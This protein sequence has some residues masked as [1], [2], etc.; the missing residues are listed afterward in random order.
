MDKDIIKSNDTKSAITKQKTEINKLQLEESQKKNVEE[1]SAVKK[2]IKHTDDAENHISFRDY[3]G[4][5]KYDNLTSSNLKINK[6]ETHKTEEPK[7]D[8]NIKTESDKQ[9]VIK[10]KETENAVKT[11]D[12]N[13]NGVVKSADSKS[14]FHQNT[15]DVSES[16][17]GN[18]AYSS[19]AFHYSEQASGQGIVKLNNS[20][21]I[22]TNNST[23]VIKSDNNVGIVKAT[24]FKDTFKKAVKRKIH[25]K[26]KEKYSKQ[27]TGK[28]GYAR[29]DYNKQE[30]IVKNTVNVINKS[31]NYKSNVN[32]KDTAFTYKDSILNGADNSNIAVSSAQNR[33]QKAVKTNIQKKQ[34]DTVKAK[35]DKKSDINAVKVVDNS[36]INTAPSVVRSMI[37][38]QTSVVK[39]S[40][41]AYRYTD[42]N[43]YAQSTFKPEPKINYN[44][45]PKNYN[46]KS[47]K[48]VVKPKNDYGIVKSSEYI[49]ADTV[50]NQ[51]ENSETQ[52]DKATLKGARAVATAAYIIKPENVVKA[53]TT[54]SS[55]KQKINKKRI[56]D[57]KKNLNIK[58]EA[59]N[60]LKKAILQNNMRAKKAVNVGK[61]AIVKGIKDGIE[62]AGNNDMPVKAIDDVIKTAD[63]VVGVKNGIKATVNTTKSAAKT[64]AS[65]ARFVKNTPKRAV[66]GAKRL[67][68]AANK[69]R[70]FKQLSMRNKTRY[71]K[72]VVKSAFKQATKVIVAASKSAAIKIGAVLLV[73]LLFV[74]IIAGSVAACLTVFMW[75]TSDDL[76]TTQIVKYISELDYTKQNELFQGKTNV[77]IERHNDSASKAWRYHY[78]L[79]VDVEPDNLNA[80]G[81]TPAETDMHCVYKDGMGSSGNELSVTYRGFNYEFSSSDDMLENFRWTTD[82]YRAALAYLQVKKSNLGWL[83]TLFGFV[84]EMQLKS[85]AKELHEQTYGT[86][87]NKNVEGDVTTFNYVNPIA[88]ASYTTSTSI[89]HYYFGR[90]FSVK[91]LI[92]NDIVRF[93]DDDDKN[94]SLKEQ[95]EYTCKYG[96]IGVANLTYPLDLAEDE[97]IA[98]KIVKHFGKQLVI[99]YAPPKEPEASDRHDVYGSIIK[100][101]GYHYANDLEAAAGDTIYAPISGLCTVTH[102]SNRGYE[103][104]I[105]TSY[106]GTT[107]DYTGKGFVIKMSC[108]GTSAFTGTR[109]VHKGDVLGTVGDIDSFSVNYSSASDNIFTSKLYPCSTGTD[110]RDIGANVFDEPDADYD[111]LHIEMYKLPCD[112]TNAAD[113]EKNVL[114]PELFFDY[115]NEE[116]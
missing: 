73:W 66:S 91:Y 106:S 74:V 84:G 76:D 90:K 15:A 96:N 41:E 98:D 34:M 101:T 95:F 31:E 10:P 114:A 28:S 42:T 12:I 107:A 47:R 112:F 63:T 85:A 61:A 39:E 103:F 51:A 29:Q 88:H 44:V 38:E 37:N 102:T 53:D 49:A 68:K 92:D 69:L 14:A 1:T 40:E 80:D 54:T 83:S 100:T 48:N 81:S 19:T 24:D 5:I 3:S 87:V 46:I 70:K 57:A 17:R 30:Q 108:A 113:M 59:A 77:E 2:N 72:I 9:S 7:Q 50:I 93:D 99:K 22:K 32:A 89:N 75:Q 56:N 6:K 23:D 35:K 20:N 94:K 52:E 27:K 79:A 25:S 11:K 86:I 115:S 65:T 111:H 45:K 43:T 33:L 16:I 116:E 104:T 71:S 67:K 4:K 109:V 97:K 55:R 110:Y 78:L 64:V 26:Q 82:D 13:N 60:S 36:Y 105:T 18:K 21:I 62:D 58:D 8:N